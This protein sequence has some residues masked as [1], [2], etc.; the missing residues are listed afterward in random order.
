MSRTSIREEGNCHYVQILVEMSHDSQEIIAMWRVIEKV[1]GRALVFVGRQSIAC[2]ALSICWASEAGL[3]RS[4]TTGGTDS[5]HGDCQRNRRLSAV[6]IPCID[7]LTPVLRT[8]AGCVVDDLVIKGPATR[9][10]CSRPPT[11]SLRLS[12]SK[13][14]LSVSAP[15]QHEAAR[16][17]N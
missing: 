17:R 13:F 5:K 3:G 4:I 10:S 7:T 14:L 12:L 11:L 6:H 9:R 8:F 1:G 2:L 15:R 16:S